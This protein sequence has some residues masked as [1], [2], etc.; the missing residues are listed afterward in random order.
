MVAGVTGAGVFY[1]GNLRKESILTFKWK[2]GSPLNL[3]EI[4]ARL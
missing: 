1:L 3:E 4:R 2:D